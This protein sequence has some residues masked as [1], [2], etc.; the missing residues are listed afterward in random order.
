MLLSK[1]VKEEKLEAI[2]VFLKAMNQEVYSNE[3]D[4]NIVDCKSDE[5]MRYEVNPSHYE[6]G[7]MKAWNKF[8]SKEIIS[9]HSNGQWSMNRL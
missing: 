9:Y 1:E 8:I 6:K 3:G 4:V 5:S 2:F 7:I